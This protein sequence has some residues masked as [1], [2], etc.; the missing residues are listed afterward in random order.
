MKFNICIAIQIKSGSI[1]ENE[2][3]IKRAKYEKP[4]F[5]ELRFDYINDIN[6]ISEDFVNALISAIQP[7]VS[8][9]FTFR[10]PSEGGQINISEK[11]RVEIIKT[12]IKSKPKYLDIEINNDTEI[13][14]EVINLASQ[15]KISLI[16]SFHDF[17]KTP[18]SDECITTINA[19][20]NRLINDLKIDSEFLEKCIYKAIFTAQNFEDN[21]VPLNV[22]KTFSKK[23]QKIICF[24]MGEIGIFSRIICVKAG[25]YLTFG[26]IDEKTAPGQL[27]I[28][29]IREIHQ[30]LFE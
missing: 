25:S 26:S 27:N 10:D 19:F 30:L 5:I 17:Q 12:L 11:E 20:E 1:E 24:C 15:N 4:E 8:A 7:E 6:L 13:L 9:I 29:K 3:I 2:I 23:G 16:F 18:S 22:C 14:S 21:F 28:K